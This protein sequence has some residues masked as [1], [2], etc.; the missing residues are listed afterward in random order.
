MKHGQHRLYLTVNYKKQKEERQRQHARLPGKH[1]TTALTL[2]PNQF[3]AAPS[4]AQTYGASP[5]NGE[6]PGQ[7]PGSRGLPTPGAFKTSSAGAGRQPRLRQRRGPGG[8]LC[9]G[10]EGLKLP[11]ESHGPS[12]AAVRR[13]AR[14]SEQP[15]SPP[16]RPR[17]PATRCHCAGRGGPPGPHRTPVTAHRAQGRRGDPAA[18]GLRGRRRS[19]APRQLPGCSAGQSPVLALGTPRHS[20]RVR[21]LGPGCSQFS[22]PPCLFYLY[23]SNLLITLF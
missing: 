4:P 5:G 2:L 10:R 11:G 15:R 9:R 8:P 12:R 19:G 7:Q 14:G 20:T 18:A 22:C 1:L 21:P 23:F 17:G 13:A 16:A 3:R 6:R